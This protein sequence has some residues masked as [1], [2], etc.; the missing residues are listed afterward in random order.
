MLKKMKKVEELE[1]SLSCRTVR[2]LVPDYVI[3]LLD[4]KLRYAV[5]KHL[6]DC[7]KCRE[8]ALEERIIQANVA[9]HFQKQ[10]EKEVRSL[11]SKINQEKAAVEP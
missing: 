8:L 1:S 7:A 6:I 2:R 10:M 9:H 3:G 11:L 5:M 4:E